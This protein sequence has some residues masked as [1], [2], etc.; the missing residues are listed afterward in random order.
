MSLDLS[1]R[2]V[3]LIAA[4][5][6][7]EQL[8]VLLRGLAVEYQCTLD[9]LLDCFALETARKFDA[10]RVSYDEA[11]G[12]MAATHAAI[13]GEEVGLYTSSGEKT[14]AAKIYWALDEGEYGADSDQG[15]DPIDVRVRPLIKEL[16][17]EAPT[18]QF[19]CR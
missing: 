14:F 16:L 3:A 17:R 10:G 13:L 9:A 4:A 18:E 15:R 2:V 11:M 19:V 1:V 7:N 12:A 5:T 8:A 6:T